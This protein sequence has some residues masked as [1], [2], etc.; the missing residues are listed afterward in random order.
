[1]HDFGKLA[2][3]DVH[4]TGS[5]YVSRFLNSCCTLE[6]VRFAKHDWVKDDYR[7]DCFYFITIRHP[8]DMWSS[9]YRYGLD[10]RGAVYLHL[11]NANL[12]SV[13]QS[14]NSFVEFCLDERNAA[15]LGFE[16]DTKVSEQVGLMSFRFLKL[17]LQFPMQQI[18]RCITNGKSLKTLEEKFITSLE[19]KNED[20][21]RY[22]EELSVEMFPQYFD[23]EK[24]RTFMRSEFRV[25]KST[26]PKDSIE[27]LSDINLKRI[28]QKEWLLMSRY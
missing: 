10:Q 26:R 11:R 13:Y 19:M 8:V 14:F 23:E 1:M 20:L 7:P 3:L 15:L 6:Q 28:H 16:Y 18:H 2:Y 27:M 12:V 4:K 17:S 5:G 22:L 24:V 25:N 9:L 21:N